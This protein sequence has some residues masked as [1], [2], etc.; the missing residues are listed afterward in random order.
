MGGEEGG[1]LTHNRIQ[2]LSIQLTA[3]Y[4]KLLFGI[5]RVGFN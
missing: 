5:M 4:D 1:S 3:D 2:L